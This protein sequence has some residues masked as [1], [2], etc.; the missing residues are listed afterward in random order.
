MTIDVSAHGRPDHRRDAQEPAHRLLDERGG[1]GD[2]PPRLPPAAEVSRREKVDLAAQMQHYWSDNQVSCTADFDPASDTGSD[3]SSDTAV[4][5]AELERVLTIYEDRLKAITFLPRESHG[6]EQ[7][8][9]EAISAGEYDQM[10]RGLRPLRGGVA[11]DQ[12]PAFLRP[13]RGRLSPAAMGCTT[14]KTLREAT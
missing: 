4:D 13:L 5:A 3:A 10:R 12:P 2:Q 9:Y 1:P 14:L 8:P 11:Q 6:Y 7:P